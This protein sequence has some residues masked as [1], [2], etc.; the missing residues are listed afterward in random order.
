MKQYRV[1]LQVCVLLLTSGLGCDDGARD[2]QGSLNDESGALSCTAIQNGAAWWN[3][4]FAEQTGRFHIEFSATPTARNIDTVIGLSNGPATKWSSLAA[5]VRFNPQGFIDARA[6]DQYYAEGSWPYTPGVT[7]Q[8]RLE[9]D[10]ASHSYA[11]WMRTTGDTGAWNSLGR[12]FAFRSEQLGVTKLNNVA[13]FTNPETSAPGGVELCGFTVVAD[14]TPTSSCAVSRAA[15][16]FVNKPLVLSESVLMVSFRARP[17]QANMDGVVGVA[18]GTVDAYDDFAASLRFY[19][20]GRLEVR[21]GDTYRADQEVTYNANQEFDVR[22][23]IDLWS[24]TYSVY[25]NTPGLTPNNDGHVRLA[26]GYR[27]RSAQAQAWQ[28][29][30]LATVVASSAGSVEVCQI[31]G[32]PNPSVQS[33]RDGTWDVQG[34]ADGSTLISKADKTVRLASNHV[35]MAS[36][37]F[38]GVSTADAT[39]NVYI[40]QHDT[41]T[42]SSRVYLASY[43]PDFFTRRWGVLLSTGAPTDIAVTPAG[44]VVVA[45]WNTPWL[46]RLS[47]TGSFIAWD[48][49]PENTYQVTLGRD[50]YLIARSNYDGIVIETFAYGD[51]THPLVT[52]QLNWAPLIE[53][54]SVAPDG[55]SIIGG[56]LYGPINFGDGELTPIVDHDT[57]TYLEAF[58]A[59]LGPDLTTR[60]SRR[61]TYK[62]HGVSA[63][64]FT[65]GR[66]FAV[67]METIRGASTVDYV[68]YNGGGDVLKSSTGDAFVGTYGVPGTITLTPTGTMYLNEVA[69]LVDAYEARH[70]FLLAVSPW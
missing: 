38:G 30:D 56:T 26:S 45:M 50:R 54:M 70:P 34:L 36:L 51:P 49:L 58:V 27:F 20:N 25:V 24:H 32:G 35:P 40:A 63:M 65:V 11:I 19:T 41:S 12:Q 48:P 60:F 37:P 6:L 7:Y 47:S 39:G 33:I 2:Q 9:V 57:G 46:A 68:V 52:R 62:V 4:S 13:A 55:S 3:Q 69:S 29:D 28:L 64:S 1:A 8:F 17:L 10:F 16:G 44:E 42:G 31:V 21:D 61:L 43:E 5:I 67:A 15:G 18:K 66:R 14:P 23:F 53:Q 22:M 59:A